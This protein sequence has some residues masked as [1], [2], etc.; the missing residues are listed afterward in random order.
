MLDDAEKRTAVA[1]DDVIS[2]LLGQKI[3]DLSVGEQRYLELCLLLHQKTTFSVIGRT[4]FWGVSLPQR[5][6]SR[7]DPQ[8]SSRKR[9]CAVRSSLS[10]RT[11]YCYKNDI[12]G[13]WWL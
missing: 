9:Y 5:T 1:E 6:Y 4:V 2:K 8:F 10:I 13:E 12:N 3:A 7:D 11:R